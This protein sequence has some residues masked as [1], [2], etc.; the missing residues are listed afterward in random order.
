MGMLFA[1]RKF[2]R[3]AEAARREYLRAFPGADPA[4]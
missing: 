2:F 1:N 3:F 4:A